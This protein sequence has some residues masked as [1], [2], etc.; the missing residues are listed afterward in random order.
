MPLELQHVS[1]PT[2][3]A[4]Q[5]IEELDEELNSAYS[6][7][8]RHGLDLSR[9]F[10]PDIL[11]FVAT[12]DGEPAGCGGVAIGDGFAELKRMYV[13]PKFRGTGV[14]Q[15]I[16]AMLEAEAA[17]NGISRVVLETGDAQLAAMRFYERMGYRKCGAFGEYATM[18]PA[19]IERSVF[20][21]K[22]MT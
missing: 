12:V 13:R 17:R 20:Y 5:L 3:E 2:P 19:S 14:A 4:R 6:P 21:E 7:E 11:F 18:P 10:R 9:I 8:Q 15:A 1:S 22:R 16:I